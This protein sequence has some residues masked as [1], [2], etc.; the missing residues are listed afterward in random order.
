MANVLTDMPARKPV[1]PLRPASAPPRRT[2][3]RAPLWHRTAAILLKGILAVA[4][5]VAAVAIARGIMAGAPSAGRVPAERQA[6]LVEVAE[7]RPAG[8]GPVIEAWGAVEPAETLVLRSEL[9]GR[10][11]AVAERLSPGEVLPEGTEIFRLD[12]RAHALRVAEAEAETRRIAAQILVEKGQAAR[13]QRDLDRVPLDLTGEQRALVLREPQ[14]QELE[15]QLAAA[16]ARRDQA[17]V[18]LAKTRVSA[19]FDALVEDEALAV[20]TVVTAG[21]EIARLV[22]VDRFR[23]MLAVAPSAFERVVDGAGRVRLSQPGVWPAGATREGRIVG[24]KAGLTEDGRM[25]E[26]LVE[27]GDPLARSPAQSGAPRLLLGAFLRAEIEGAPIGGAVEIDRSWL[28]ADETVWV[29]NADGR[30]EIRPVE[31]AWRGRDRVLVTE[32]V[33]AG[34]RVVATR[35]A[36]VTEGMALR[37][38]DTPETGS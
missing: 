22:A 12:D 33:A 32:G 37:T 6:R 7:V 23:V 19:P 5:L 27:V 3:R 29:M 1:R 10:V 28:R 21:T 35:L 20:G 15:A 9:A 11:T 34:E 13:A 24:T 14:M 36:V 26:I 31:I 25:A 2:R 8:K 16:Q 4:V 30:L 18:E 17:E 38:A